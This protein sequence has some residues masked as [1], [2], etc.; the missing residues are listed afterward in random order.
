[1]A[2]TDPMEHPVTLRPRRAAPKSSVSA[3]RWSMDADCDV[4]ARLGVHSRVGM[5]GAN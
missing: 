2:P 5:H 1:M 4:M 3:E